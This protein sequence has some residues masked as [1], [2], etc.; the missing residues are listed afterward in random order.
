[1]TVHTSYVSGFR[2]GSWPES[3]LILFRLVSLE[4]AVKNKCEEL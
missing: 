2:K 1:M 3:D 4:D